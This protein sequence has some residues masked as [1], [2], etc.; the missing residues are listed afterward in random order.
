MTTHAAPGAAARRRGPS[1]AFLLLLAAAAL[2]IGGG[3]TAAVLLA[4][5]SSSTT[6][7]TRSVVAATTVVQTVKVT[8][9]SARGGSTPAT[10][11]PLTIGGI[12]HL[13]REYAAAYSAKDAERLERLFAPKVA[14]QIGTDV[15]ATRAQALAAY[16]RQFSG[17]ASPRFVFDNMSY[18]SV[19]GDGQAA[20]TYVIEQAGA[21]M[22]GAVTF[23]FVSRGGRA[24]IDRITVTPS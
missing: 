22:H 24:L 21:T 6:T 4:V 11:A 16:R 13:L 17:L 8:Q 9:S 23:H 15:I 20:G 7:V 2:A 5:R 1:R 18:S 19:N 10:G 3:V 12:Q 14:G